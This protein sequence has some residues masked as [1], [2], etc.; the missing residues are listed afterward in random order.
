[1][2]IDGKSIASEIL[3]EVKNSVTHL[4]VQPHLTV[5]TCAPNFETKKYLAL[6]RRKASEVGIGV[7]VIELPETV[8]TEEAHISV[9]HSLMQ[10]DGVIVQLPFPLYIDIETILKNI[11]ASYDVDA[12]SYDGTGEILPPVVG[13]IAEIAARHDLL[14]AT[15]NVVVVGQGRLVG[16][17]AAIWAQKQGGNVTVLTKESKNTEACI[18]EADVLILGAGVPN[19]VKSDMIKDGVVIF[20]AG[21]SEDGGVLRGD[22]DPNCAA[23]ASLFTPVPGGIGPITVAILLKNLVALCARAQST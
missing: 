16:I 10:T 14:I 2:I 9:M 12:L 23:K 20:D 15:Q 1:M 13:A 7:N 11:P 17:P 5:F 18:K 3:A 6:K 19:L 22:A 4:E 21:T 8:T